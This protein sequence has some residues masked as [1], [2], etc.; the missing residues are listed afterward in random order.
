[1]E[2]TTTVVGFDQLCELSGL[3][4]P[5]AVRRWLKGQRVAFR[6][7]TRGRPFTSAALL[8][9]EERERI[10]ASLAEPDFSVLG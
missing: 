1:M 7:D 5:S 2:L 6:T 3:Q 4:R 8:F 9:P 10:E